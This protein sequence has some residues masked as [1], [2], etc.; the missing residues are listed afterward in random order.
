MNGE[1]EA[2]LKAILEMDE[3]PVE[4]LDRIQSCL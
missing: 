4:W 2:L 3:L 1:I